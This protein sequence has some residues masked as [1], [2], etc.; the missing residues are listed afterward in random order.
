MKRGSISTPPSL[1][2]K[3][4]LYVET[5]SALFLDATKTYSGRTT[6]STFNYLLLGLYGA[7][8]DAISCELR[9]N[10]IDCS[11]VTSYHFDGFEVLAVPE[12]MTH[13]GDFLRVPTTQV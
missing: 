9:F 8:C 10:L 5:S 11:F 1:V 2:I 12:H 7:T 6:L 13:D 3:F 4:K